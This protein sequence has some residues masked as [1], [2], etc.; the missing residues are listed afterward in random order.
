[1][2]AFAEASVA[3]EDLLSLLELSNIWD[4][5]ELKEQAVKAIV[6]LRLVRVETCDA[7]IERAEACQAEDLAQVCRETKAQNNWT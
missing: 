4:V 5:P 3:L 2:G 7:V 1:M 6:E